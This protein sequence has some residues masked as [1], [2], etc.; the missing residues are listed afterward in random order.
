MK[1]KPLVKTLG[2]KSRLAPKILE[3]LPSTI[4]GTYFE[5]FC[6]GAAVF[7]ALH[8][9]GRLAPTATVHLNDTNH[10]MI[11]LLADVRDDIERLVA[12]LRALQAAYDNATA[13]SRSLLYSTIRDVWNSSHLEK[14]SA[15][16]VFLKQTAFNG[17]WRVNKSGDM[18]A[19]WGKYETP[20]IL[21]ED[22]L[23]AWHVALKEYGVQLWKGDA[24]RWRMQAKPEAGDV[25][26]LDPPY[27][28]TFDGYDAAG[29]TFAQ[30]AE[31][32]VL[33]RSF[34]QKGAV[35]AYSNS[36]SA[37]GLIEAAWPT[38]KVV[39][40]STSYTVNTDGAGRGQEP[41]LLVV[42]HGVAAPP[43]AP[44]SRIVR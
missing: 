10:A 21:D 12:D 33:A 11:N 44:R 26:Y 9:A 6:G 34:V 35:V 29:F 22:N 13:E 17:L 19:A 37:R 36:V 5:P 30:H 38:G 20:R 3:Y 14:T 31:L 18:N 28:D 2:G 40:L 23:R 39:E 32:L 25:V 4:T 1:L 41:E 16:F 27:M 24:L 7:V 8:N 42:E 15:R 43:R